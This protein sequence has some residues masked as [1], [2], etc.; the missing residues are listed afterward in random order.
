MMRPIH[1]RLSALCLPLFFWRRKIG[2]FG[3][4]NPDADCVAGTR[5]LVSPS[6]AGGGS[7]TVGAR[8]G[9]H[10]DAGSRS[11]LR[12]LSPQ[13]VALRAPTFPLQGKVK[14]REPTGERFD[15]GT[16]AQ[17]QTA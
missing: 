10:G 15:D 2:G 17:Q 13:P 14:R 4:Q 1:L 12:A 5:A 16:P 6:P 7:R 11:A 8:G 9:V 3:R